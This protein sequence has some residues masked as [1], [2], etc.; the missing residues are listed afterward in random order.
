MKNKP[1]KEGFAFFVLAITTLF[2]LNSSPDERTATK[3][4]ESNKMNCDTNS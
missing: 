3:P 4:K 2:V 1:M